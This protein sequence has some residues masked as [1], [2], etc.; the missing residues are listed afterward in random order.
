MLLDS[1]IHSLLISYLYV[2]FFIT[3]QSFISYL[4]LSVCKHFILGY[5]SSFLKEEVGNIDELVLWVKSWIVG[6]Q[7]Y[8]SL[9]CRKKKSVFNCVQ[10]P[11]NACHTLTRSIFAEFAFEK[12]FRIQEELSHSNRWCLYETT[13]EAVGNKAYLLWLVNL[14][15]NEAFTTT[16]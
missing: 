12:L 6:S 1:F 16:D 8:L 14:L 9:P 5:V 11:R 13:I 2:Y 3:F 7:L 4:C 10:R 15:V